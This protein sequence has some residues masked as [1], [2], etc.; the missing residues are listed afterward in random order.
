[1]PKKPLENYFF[2]FAFKRNL[3]FLPTKK[4]IILAKMGPHTP[5]PIRKLFFFGFGFSG[6]LP[7][8]PN[9]L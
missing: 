3:P 6:N 2:F 7:F 8:L 9:V 4:T 1:M 5:K